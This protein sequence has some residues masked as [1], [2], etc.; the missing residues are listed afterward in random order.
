MYTSQT[1]LTSL[2]LQNQSYFQKTMVCGVAMLY[3][4]TM[5]WRVTTNSLK[6]IVMLHPARSDVKIGLTLHM[7]MDC[8][9]SYQCNSDLSYSVVV[10]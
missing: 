10:L 4:K 2:L 1:D 7:E 3:V 5:I 9:T 6:I 8:I